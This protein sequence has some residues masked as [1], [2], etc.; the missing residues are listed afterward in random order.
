M[1]LNNHRNLIL[2]C[3]ISVFVSN[4]QCNT[5]DPVC[6]KENDCS[7]RYND[8]TGINL[9][10]LIS[11]SSTIKYFQLILSNLQTVY[12]HPCGDVQINTFANCSKASVR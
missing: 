8:G 5:G 4:I 6:L 3:L 1:L 7:C 9:Q 11:P 2:L 10:T 12:Y